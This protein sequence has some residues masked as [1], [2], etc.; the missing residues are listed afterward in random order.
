M[1][2][3][4]SEADD[5]AS[6]LR[7]GHDALLVSDRDALW[8]LGLRGKLTRARSDRRAAAARVVAAR[9]RASLARAAE[10]AE[11]FGGNGTPIPTRRPK[12]VPLA[13]YRARAG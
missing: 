10:L 4:W 9:A 3:T 2:T 8:L 1:K 12:V 13:R 5:G 7:M 11:V 6:N